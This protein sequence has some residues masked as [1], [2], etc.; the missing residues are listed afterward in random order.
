MFIDIFAS[1]MLLSGKSRNPEKW[2]AADAGIDRVSIGRAKEDKQF[3]RKKNKKS[4]SKSRK[5]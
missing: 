4:I 3:N 5:D 2:V 1:V